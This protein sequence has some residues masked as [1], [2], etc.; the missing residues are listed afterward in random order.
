MHAESLS[1]PGRGKVLESHIPE[2]DDVRR[3]CTVIVGLLP[4]SSCGESAV[5]AVF[6]Q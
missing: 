3:R 4:R 2:A 1:G 5:A 6:E